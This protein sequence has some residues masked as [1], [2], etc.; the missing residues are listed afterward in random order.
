[1]QCKAKYEALKRI[2]TLISSSGKVLDYLASPLVFITQNFNLLLD[3]I[4]VWRTTS[5]QKT[6][7]ESVCFK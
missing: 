4:K 3:Q 1:M 7:Q 6:V 5:E 2:H